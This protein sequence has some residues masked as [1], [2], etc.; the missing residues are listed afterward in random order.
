MDE[1]RLVGPQK[2]SKRKDGTVEICVSQKREEGGPGRS[3]RAM[4]NFNYVIMIIY[5]LF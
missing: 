3:R 5:F 4:M 1:E 2:A